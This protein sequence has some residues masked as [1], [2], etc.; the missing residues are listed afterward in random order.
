MCSN[1][2]TLASQVWSADGWGWD[3]PCCAVRFGFVCICVVLSSVS[4]LKRVLDICCA[5]S[6]KIGVGQFI[7]GCGLF[8]CS[9]HLCIV[10]IHNTHGCFFS[11]SSL[12]LFL[13]TLLLAHAGC[14]YLSGLSQSKLDFCSC[15]FL[16]V[17]YFFLPF[18]C[19]SLSTFTGVH[20]LSSSTLQCPC[21]EVLEDQSRDGHELKE[22]KKVL[23]KWLLRN[24]TFTQKG[25]WSTPD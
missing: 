6:S 25:G 1:T 11:L 15:V 2:E 19:L 9:Q 18:T 5:V 8:E 22:I 14:A 16:F 17:C 13:P 24:G 3:L 10:C 4:F 23:F 20:M 12:F 21:L 7:L